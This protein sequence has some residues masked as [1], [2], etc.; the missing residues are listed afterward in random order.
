MRDH[1]NVIGSELPSR[2]FR[3]TDY[4]A[5]PDSGEDATGAIQ[6]ALAAAC[7]A[8]G[9]GVVEFP[10][11][12]YDLYPDH[13]VKA[14][15]Y[16]SNTASEAE[17]PD[18]TKTIGLWLKGANRISLEGNGSKLLYHG[19]MTTI[20]LDGCCEAEIRNLTIDFARPTIS[21]MRIVSIG[22]GYWDTEVHSDSAYTLEDGKLS[23]VG[24]GWSYR[25]GP[26]QEYDPSSNRTWRVPDPM[27]SASRVEQLAPGKLR[28]RFAPEEQ[29]RTAVGHVFQM[30][31]GIRDQ[32]G[33]LIV[34][35]RDIVWR[36]VRMQ[37]MHG[38]GI[39]GQFSE[40]LSFEGLRLAPDPSGGRTA[41]AFA[42]FAH[43][44]GMKGKLSIVDSVFEGA[45]DDAINVH[46]THLRI[47]GTEDGER[48]RV[49]F[50]HPQSYGFVAFHPGDEIDFI[51]ADTLLP[52]AT[53]TVVGVQR[54][55]LREAE[56]TLNAPAPESIAEGDVVE[57]VTWTPEVE[58]R[59]NV[60]R[61]I[62]TRGILAT[63]RRKVTI[64]DNLFEKL[65]MS[66]ILIADDA[67]SWFESGMVRH[68]RIRGNR[69]A[70]CGGADHATIRIHPENVCVSPDHPVHRNIV[71]SGNRFELGEAPLL[72]AKSATD[73]IVADN[74]VDLNGEKSEGPVDWSEIIQLCACSGVEIFGN[75]IE[76]GKDE[77][78]EG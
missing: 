20:V 35:C 78:H 3:V 58:I 42:D 16:V 27:A 65:H 46:G 71:I 66:A 53:R 6:A 8:K 57:N 19:K 29:P 62:P 18:P 44:S 77:G 32:V 4:G 39:V 28:L 61:S 30:R 26:A 50:M 47:R 13:A 52:Y 38:L 9:P 21:E 59:G 23:W 17:H 55:S 69:F 40:N 73:L 41:A 5:R 2:L 31:D 75:T 45:H 56:L 36:N 22:E 49:R 72:E 76:H 33:A 11:G 25:S 70:A 63:T 1:T 51:S 54:L 7:A 74:H 15:Y 68:V 12:C 37:Y 24:E 10:H 48:I 64:E 60:F 34:G 67:G 43:F 14:P